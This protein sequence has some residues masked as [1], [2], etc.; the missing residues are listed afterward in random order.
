MCF[1]LFCFFTL[2]PKSKASILQ[3]GL[4]SVHLTL[5]ELTQIPCRTFSPELN[6]ALEPPPR[7]L[8]SMALSEGSRIYSFPQVH[9]GSPAR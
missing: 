9:P 2:L 1:V 7:A 3:H 4:V 6:L 5:W 8:V